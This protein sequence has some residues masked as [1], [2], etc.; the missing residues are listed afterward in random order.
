[1][2][3]NLENERR[4]ELEAAEKIKNGELDN[5]EVLLKKN[6]TKNT[7][8]AD[9]Y[10]LL[11]KI[12]KIRNDYTNIIKTINMAIRFANENKKEFKELKRTILLNK[13]IID[14]FDNQD[15][16]KPS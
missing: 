5:A 6:L 12:Y 7:R 13:L 16:K 15:K 8:S 4:I 11:I 1:M 14:I 2:R 3:T 9:T 10:K